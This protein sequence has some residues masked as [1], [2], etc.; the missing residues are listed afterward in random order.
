MLLI[1][2]LEW[3]TLHFPG[4]E[5]VPKP[6]KIPRVQRLDVTEDGREKGWPKGKGKGG[7]RKGKESASSDSSPSRPK[8]PCQLFGN[9]E[10]GCTYGSKCRFSHDL[11]KAKKDQLCFH[12]GMPGHMADKCPSEVA[13]KQALGTANQ[14]PKPSAKA[15][16]KA[17]FRKAQGAGNTEIPEMQQLQIGSRS[18]GSGHQGVA[19]LVYEDGAG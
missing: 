4:S 12:C 2:E 9:G 3:S 19:R 1:S 10:L 6:P 17:S 8:K 5:T 11:E 16:A 15:K 7:K 13:R 18:V 14:E